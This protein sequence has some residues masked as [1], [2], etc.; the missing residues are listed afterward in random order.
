MGDA[1]AQVIQRAK[2]RLGKVLRDKW[3]LDELLGIGGMAAV[4]SA[5]HRN[6]KRAAIKVL[7]PEAALV[8]DIKARFLQEG[9]LANRV[10][11][12]GALSILDDDVDEDG[13]VFLVMELLHG[14]TLEERWQHNGRL[15]WQEV[16]AVAHQAL[17]VL[18]AAHE[19][20][21]VHRDIKPGNV[22]IDTSTGVKILD[23]GIARL[24]AAPLS[25]SKTGHDTA[26]GTPG[27]IPPEQARGRSDLVDARSDLWGLGATMFAVLA[28]HHVHEADTANEQLMLAMTAPAMSLGEAAPDV[29]ASVV[30]VV[31]RALKYD[32]DQRYPDARAM[33]AALAETYQAELGESIAGAPRL[34]VLVGKLSKSVHPDAPT[35]SAGPNE[36][37]TTARPVYESSASGSAPTRK[38]VIAL[39]AVGLVA[40]PIAI[41]LAVRSNP[42]ESASAR[43]EASSAPPTPPVSASET[44]AATA[45]TTSEPETTQTAPTPTAST[46]P[47]ASS[48]AEEQ[49]SPVKRQPRAPAPQASAGKSAPSATAIDIFERRH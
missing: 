33:Q 32:K 19:K 7:Q 2:E 35:V 34:S 21:I 1:E 44:A 11:H 47:V 45:S 3:R 16:V 39:V 23:F 6:G 9:Y 4:Y 41:W 25:T 36:R 17:E 8:P 37:D 31:D 29:P 22:F 26:L 13:T 48:K 12:P 40:V 10:G 27:F 49:P 5:T 18:A 46:E 24:N 43:A 28:G 38:R 14:E 30:A 15:P 20:D 42:G